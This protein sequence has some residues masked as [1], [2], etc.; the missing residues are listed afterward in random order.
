VFRLKNLQVVALFNETDMGA[1][2]GIAKTKIGVPFDETERMVTEP[3]PDVYPVI[4]P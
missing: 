3:K 2:S 1:S 4:H